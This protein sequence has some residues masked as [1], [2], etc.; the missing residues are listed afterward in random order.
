MPATEHR[1]VPDT[2]HRA[3]DHRVLPLAFEGVGLREGGRELLSG[4]S[5][6]LDAGPCSVI[7][8][9]NGA[10][11]TM[12][13]RLAMGLRAPTSGAVRWHGTSGANARDACAMVFQRPLMLRRSALSNIDYALRLRRVPAEERGRRIARVLEATGLTALAKRSARLL[14]VGEQQRLAIARAWALQPEVLFLD[15]PAASLD[16]GSSRALEASIA[17]IRAEGTK[18]VMTTH[19]LLQARRMADEVLFLHRGRLL[20]QTPADQFFAL[21]RSVDARKFIQG[22]ILT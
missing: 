22:E 3:A 17:A 2:E 19:D 14:S 4:L 13:L 10:G 12:T 7:L 15:E 8:G 20:E 21:P 18:I 9:P 11:K 16:P 6:R 5:F 1:D